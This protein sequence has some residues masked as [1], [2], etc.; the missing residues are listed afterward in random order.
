[1]SSKSVTGKTVCFAEAGIYKCSIKHSL[2][3]FAVRSKVWVCD[4][5]VAE[6]A[7]SNSGGGMEFCLLWVLCVVRL[8]GS[9]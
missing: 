6:I 5:Q 8:S 7:G 1:M 9:G 2:S 4:R 3:Q